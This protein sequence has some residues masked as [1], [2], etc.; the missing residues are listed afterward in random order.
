MLELQQLSIGRAGKALFMPLTLAISRGYCLHIQGPNGVGKTTLIK[1]L[2]G[3]RPIQQ[4]SVTWLARSPADWGDDFRAQL[5]Y[6]GHRDALKDQLSP[7]ENLLQY[8]QMHNVILSEERALN[9]LVRVGLEYCIDSP[10]RRLSQGQKRRA[11]LAR[12]MAFSRP[13]WL[14]DEPLVALD[15]AGQHELGDWIAEH[16]Q[17][18]GIAVLSS[19]QNLPRSIAD[20]QIVTLT[21]CVESAW[22]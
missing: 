12:F 22:V 20:A 1:T 17:Q 14:M 18:G 9:T 13:I 11:A 10:V 15:V 21:P 6:L 8:A 2:A 7:L 19:H 5:H 3:L 4:G 16:L